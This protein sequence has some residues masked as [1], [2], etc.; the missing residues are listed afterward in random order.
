MSSRGAEGNRGEHSGVRRRL[1]RVRKRDGR[2]VP[3]DASK[4]ASA[5]RKATAATGEVEERYA[6][7]VAELVELALIQE[8]RTRSTSAGAAPANSATISGGATGEYVP[9]IE[10]IQDLV[11]RVLVETGKTTVAKAYILYRDQ[12]SRVREAVRVE[13][14]NLSGDVHV[15][16]AGG[17]SA[18]SKGRI[19]AALMTE[20]ELS[21][22]SAEEVASAVE[23]KVFDSGLSRITTGLV[24]ELVDIELVAR[25]WT[26][27]L[28]RQEPV[29]L[30]RHDVR[31]VLAG[32]PF[33]AWEEESWRLADGNTPHA[34]APW[35]A[36]L[37]D[38]IEGPV[39][40][41]VL[42]RF[43]L[44]EILD[45]QTAEM[46]LSGELHIE[47]LGR[48]HLP[49]VLSINSE[50]IAR[51]EPSSGAAFALLEEL[52]TLTAEC[53]YGIVLEDPGSV[54]QPLVRGTRAKSPLGLAAWL[55]SASAIARASRRRIDL[56]SPGERFSA[57]TARLVEELALTSVTGPFAPRLFL[58]VEE[59]QSLMRE[60]VEIGEAVR[61]LCAE[62]RII[63]SWSGE[64]EHFAAP[65]CRRYGREQGALAASGAV[66][67][68]LPR[69]AQRAG[70]WREDTLFELLSG[71]V[72][73]A[74]AAARSIES[75]RAKWQHRSS[76][77]A[78]GT[79]SI[80]PIGLRET[81]RYLG[82]GQIDPEQGARVVGFLDEAARR[83]A[84][85][86]GLS[87]VISPFFGERARLRF[88]SADHERSRQL[89]AQQG[90][91]FAVDAIRREA[92]YSAGFTL[93][94]VYGCEAGEAE[95]ELVTTLPSGALYPAPT[96][97]LHDAR[98]SDRA[99]FETWARCHLRR[100]SVAHNLLFP[101]ASPGGDASPSPSTST[102]PVRS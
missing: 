6:V 70:P 56:G 57:F 71:S 84:A 98:Q 101:K 31:R 2:E 48:P 3:F 26:A 78:R 58:D 25:G 44:R 93:S 73:C 12:R 80:V 38:R 36:Q 99:P 68:N 88:A 21:R 17:T 28:L 72:Q 18:W 91:L 75:A 67:I 69:L 37:G 49:L 60:S 27:A 47:D 46:H 45:E 77:R 15:R 65:G 51:G 87:A 79:W 83:F 64:T 92:P 40:G 34:P 41:E 19:V 82:D 89:E 20:A 43:A 39:S 52:A 29:S 50:L 23:N 16:D 32:L 5:V 54:L 8:N 100:S 61:R 42:T 94:P 7:E 53:A 102:N 9:T 30:P 74:L 62:G 33:R 4:I 76:I 10:E 95:A 13:N 86:L 90:E 14:V 63:L 55:R 81:L 1:T 59:C 97:S 11:E 85:D 66:A 22:G 96:P 24:R 35:P